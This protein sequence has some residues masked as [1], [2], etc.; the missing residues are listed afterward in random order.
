MGYTLSFRIAGISGFSL[1]TRR[2]GSPPP[3]YDN[4]YV[5]IGAF[6]ALR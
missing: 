1:N 4:R 2:T 6:W 5:L 3:R